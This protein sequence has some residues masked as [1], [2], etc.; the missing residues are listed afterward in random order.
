MEEVKNHTVYLVREGNGGPAIYVGKAIDFEKRK[1]VYLS[2]LKRPRSKANKIK[3]YIYDLLVTG[4]EPT[5]E[6]L[7]VTPSEEAALS[8]KK[9][10]KRYYRGMGEFL[11]VSK[12]IQQTYTTYLIRHPTTQKVFYIGQTSDFTKRCKEHLRISKRGR[13][14]IKTENIKT[15]M[16]DL[17]ASGLEP[18]FEIIEICGS[19]EESLTSETKWVQHYAELGEPLLNRWKEHRSIIKKHQQNK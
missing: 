3:A 15:N 18:N 14:N 8:A 4:I 7:E 1:K 19:E 6:V 2:S 12:N 9:R 13:P 10:W 11:P 5:F 16:Y 17:L